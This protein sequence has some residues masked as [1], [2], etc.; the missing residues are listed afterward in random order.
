MLQRV[1]GKKLL[2]ESGHKQG[3]QEYSFHG[4]NLVRL[5]SLHSARTCLRPNL[6]NQEWASVDAQRGAAR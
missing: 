2:P 1:I 5:Q 6:G 3:K 4:M